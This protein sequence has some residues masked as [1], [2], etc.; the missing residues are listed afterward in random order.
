[1]VYYKES[2]GNLSETLLKLKQ[3]KEQKQAFEQ[4]KRVEDKMHTVKH[5][6]SLTVYDEGDY[7]NL[8][9]WL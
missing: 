6:Y 4:T 9:N 3:V 7:H 5:S 1:M 2:D 8:L